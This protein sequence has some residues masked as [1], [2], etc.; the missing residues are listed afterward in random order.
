LAQLPIIDFV[1]SRD[2]KGYRLEEGP[3][4]RIVRNGPNRSEEFCRP[5]GGEEF[6]I[7][8]SIAGS[9]SGALE[10]VQRYG[11]LTWAGWDETGGDYVDLVIRN[12]D[13]MREL[14]NASCEGSSPVTKPGA[15]S[16]YSTLHA[17]VIWDP[18]AKAL[19]WHFQ[20]NTLLDALW[21]QFGQE[22]TRGAK[23][24]AC[25]HCGAWFEAGAG[26]GRRADAKFCSDEHRVNFNS[27]KR[28]KGD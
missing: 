14:L 27:L 6:R 5:L 22:V 1:W 25:Q 23:I 2:P 26:T 12:A 20:P 17:C 19:K 8:A 18:A 28:S 24:R 21:L 10:F 16:P 4:R 7:F 11:P 13:E 15:M 3:P 9:P